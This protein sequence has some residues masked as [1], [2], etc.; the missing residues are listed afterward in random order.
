MTNRIQLLILCATMCVTL[1]LPSRLHE[2]M[3]V[4]PTISAKQQH[5][6]IQ[7]YNCIKESLYY[8]ASGEGLVGLTAVLSVIYNRTQHK[9]Y[10]STY[11]GVIQQ[12]Y[13]F[14]YRNHLRTG[15]MMPAIKR[16]LNALE[17][18][19]ARQVSVLAFEATQGTFKPI[20]DPSVTMY[21]SI[22]MKYSL[23]AWATKDKFVIT[24]RNHRFYKG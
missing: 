12:K 1:A 13:Q 17:Q 14:S 22:K 20:L 19:V 10:P 7:Q 24:I 6:L 23:P 5:Q 2:S 16:P 15:Q 3:H 11:C 4:T 8:E 9:G 18:K 21:H